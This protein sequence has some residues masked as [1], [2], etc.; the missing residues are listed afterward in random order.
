MCCAGRRREL[1]YPTLADKVSIQIVA[2]GKVEE[3]RLRGELPWFLKHSS[4]ALRLQSESTE[5]NTVH[6]CL[7]GILAGEGG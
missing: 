3:C 2:L 6:V 4:Y 5:T 7:E 1:S